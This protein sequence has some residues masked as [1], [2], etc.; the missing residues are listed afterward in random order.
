MQLSIRLYCAQRLLQRAE[1]SAAELCTLRDTAVERL[2]ACEAALHDAELQSSAL[3]TE[4]AESNASHK[5]EVLELAAL[6]S[7]ANRK[8]EALEA[9]LEA[10][11]GSQ[12][13]LWRSALQRSGVFA[14]QRGR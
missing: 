6:L 5:A 1:G 11:C 2:S 3:V 10:R 4:L 12:S 9:S 13:A 7:S 14:L 8:L